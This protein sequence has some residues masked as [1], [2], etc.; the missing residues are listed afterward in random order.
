MLNTSKQWRLFRLACQFFTRIPVGNIADFQESDLNQATR[1][2]SLVGLVVAAILSVVFSGLIT[3]FPIDLSVVLLLIVSVL[4]TGAFHEDGLA[5][6][7]DGI[8]GG[9]TVSSRLAI[10]K[11]SR[12]GT[13]GAISLFLVMLLKYVLLVHIAH[14][15]LM[16]FSLFFAHAF[17]RA[18]A[19]S[20]IADTPYVSEDLSSKSKPLAQQQSQKDCLL[21]MLIG[22]LP[23]LFIPYTLFSLTFVIVLVFTLLIFRAVF[24][25]WLIA[26]IEGFT[27]DCLGACQQLTELIIYML[28]VAFAI[29]GAQ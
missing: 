25:R 14:A 12:L 17:S 1:Y 20:L 7:A 10:M 28:I 2:F 19:A 15:E 29:G 13:Y 4:L 22:T 16:L 27:G 21:V 9:Y 11:D 18:I 24:R 6:M 26:R 23:L 3:F 5:D 8:G